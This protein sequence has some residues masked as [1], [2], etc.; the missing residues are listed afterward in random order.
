MEYLIGACVGTILL[1]ITFPIWFNL[2]ILL[3]WGLDF[4]D[5]DLQ[6]KRPDWL[7]RDK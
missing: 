2:L 7:K 4:I 5:M 3:A 6:P 1:V